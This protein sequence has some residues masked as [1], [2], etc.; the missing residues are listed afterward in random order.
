MAVAL[1]V[2]FSVTRVALRVRVNDTALVVVF[3]L[4]Y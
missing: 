4:V 1:T 3:H 2:S